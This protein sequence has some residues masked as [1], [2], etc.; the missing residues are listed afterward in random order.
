MQRNTLKKTCWIDKAT[1]SLRSRA[2]QFDL[3]L[4]RFIH[5]RIK[6]V[7]IRTSV[8]D[9]PPSIGR[10]KTRVVFTVPRAP[11]KILA[12]RQAMNRDFRHIRDRTQNRSDRQP[13]VE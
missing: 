3:D 4:A 7:E 8:V 12:G 13:T 11:L 10:R 2:V 6:Q 1:F 5:S 9:D